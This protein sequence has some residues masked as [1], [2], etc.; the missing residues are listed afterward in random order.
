MTHR[1]KTVALDD[2]HVPSNRTRCT[3]PGELMDL[4]TRGEI[5]ITT[6]VVRWLGH[7]DDTDVHLSGIRQLASSVATAGLIHPIII[8]SNDELVDGFRRI[9]AHALLVAQGRAEFTTISAIVTGHHWS[10]DQQLAEVM[11]RDGLTAIET[12]INLAW[13]IA[14][15]EEERFEINNP[16]V[17]PHG[18]ITVPVELHT[19]ALRHRRHGTWDRVVAILGK[20]AGRWDQYIHLLRLCDPAL[21]IAHRAGL[22]EGSLRKIVGRDLSCQQQVALV[23]QLVEKTPNGYR[24]RPAIARPVREIQQLLSSISLLALLPPTQLDNVFADVRDTRTPDEYEAL[25]Q[26]M[27]RI[28]I[29]L[30]HYSQTPG[31]RAWREIKQTLSSL[32]Y[33]TSLQPDSMD[34]AIAGFTCSRTSGDLEALHLALDRVLNALRELRGLRFRKACDE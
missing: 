13:L 16:F 19:V 14:E 29:V 6:A 34:D 28:Y 4:L 24:S 18:T 20:T 27:E 8:R 5:P 26:V 15:I 31:G 33:L 21:T 11:V 10:L 32:D 17:G 25:Y 22:T 23:R 2:I 30:G 9:L 1:D 7:T 12:C 3:L